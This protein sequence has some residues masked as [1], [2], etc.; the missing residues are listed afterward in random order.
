MTQT[1]LVTGGSGF[2]AGHV[3]D[4]FL[5]AGYN[6]KATV[7]SQHS[8]DGMAS[9][10]KDRAGQLSFV[11]V[12]DIAAEGA[13]DDAVKDVDGVI[14][15]ASP[16]FLDAKDYEKELYAAAVAGTAN[17][18]K[19][20]KA[21]NP[22]VKRIVI[23]SSFAANIDVSKGKRAGY[24]YSES[25]WNPMP[26]DEVHNPVEAYLVSKELAEK[27]AWDFI[28]NEKPNFTIATLTPA[29]VYGPLRHHVTSVKSLNTSSGDLYRLFSGDTKEIPPTEFAAYVDVRDRK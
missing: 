1:V 3:L 10:H 28:E 15:T 18:L 25:D 19:S 24:N 6:V 14:H 16:F 5:N 21:H 13:L 2:I 29:M 12:E 26:K 17:V 22:S 8:A 23:T 27:A 9:M 20:V 11:I 4:V 7:R